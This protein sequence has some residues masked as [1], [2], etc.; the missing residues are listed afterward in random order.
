M[1]A[2]WHNV[3][4]LVVV[5]GILQVD[6][7]HPVAWLEGIS[8]HVDTLHLEVDCLH[9]GVQTLQI[10]NGSLTTIVLYYVVISVCNVLFSPCALFQ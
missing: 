7:C 9:K 6:L 3:C 4:S 2:V 10:D 1:G 8:Q 5:R